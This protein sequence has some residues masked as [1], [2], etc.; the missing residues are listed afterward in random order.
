MIVVF[1]INVPCAMTQTLLLH[2]M[3]SALL[4]ACNAHACADITIAYL[5]HKISE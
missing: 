3:Q 4:Q 1:M 2:N 5:V